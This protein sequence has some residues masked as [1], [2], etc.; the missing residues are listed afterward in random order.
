MYLLK[1]LGAVMYIFKTKTTKYL[2]KVPIFKLTFIN[3]KFL[4][5]NETR[6]KKSDPNWLFKN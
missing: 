5:L 3:Q 6:V 1:N 4:G 2:L